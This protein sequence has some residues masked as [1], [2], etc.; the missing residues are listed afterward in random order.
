M[1][2]PSEEG[3]VFQNNFAC[4]SMYNI[5]QVNV[6]EPSAEDFVVVIE[7]AIA[8]KLFNRDNIPLN[9]HICMLIAV[10]ADGDHDASHAL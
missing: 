7:I 10:S 6:K 5:I 8:T 1:K 3:S 2:S 4:S 9:A